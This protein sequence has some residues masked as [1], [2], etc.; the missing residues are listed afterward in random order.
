[1]VLFPVETWPKVLMRK[2][3][4]GV[5][6]C[7]RLHRWWYLRFRRFDVGRRRIVRE[8]VWENEI[9]ERLHFRVTTVTHQHNVVSVEKAATLPD[10][11][12]RQYAEKVNK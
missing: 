3:R 6:C 10:E 7:A 8:L 9:D 2:V 12:R 5:D 1:M 11:E 4:K